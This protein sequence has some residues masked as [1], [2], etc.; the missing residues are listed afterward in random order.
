MSD[1]SVFRF[2]PPF[3]REQAFILLLNATAFQPVEFGLDN[4]RISK[5]NVAVKTLYAEPDACD[6]FLDLIHRAR[7]EG[8]L[9]ALCGLY[10]ADRRAFANAVIPF[11]NDHSTAAINPGGCDTFLI[12]FSASRTSSTVPIPAPSASSPTSTSTGTCTPRFNKP[13]RPTR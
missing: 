11:L 1:D 3:T 13:R 8:K 4:D 6:I 9:Y 12:P 10:N 2:E 7:N 5:C